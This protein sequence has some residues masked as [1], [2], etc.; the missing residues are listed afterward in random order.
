MAR[1]S[2]NVLREVSGE[3]IYPT[4]GEG[5]PARSCRNR[6]RMGQDRRNMPDRD[7]LQGRQKAI[8]R[9]LSD[10]SRLLQGTAQTPV[11]APLN[12]HPAEAMRRVSGAAL[13]RGTAHPGRVVAGVRCPRTASPP[14]TR[15]PHLLLIGDE[16]PLTVRAGR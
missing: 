15:P 8:D 12:A 14:S 13:S 5:I 10:I 2:D 7:L 11:A 4:Q 3:R 1:G 16:G 6:G 9:L